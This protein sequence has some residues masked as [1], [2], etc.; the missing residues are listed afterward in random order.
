[1]ALP[2]RARRRRARRRR[3][4]DAR[5]IARFGLRCIENGHYGAFPTVG[6]GT[7][8]MGDLLEA[9]VAATDSGA[10]LVWADEKLVAGQGVE[11][12]SGLPLWAVAEGESGAVWDVHSERA[13]DAGLVC[14]PIAETVR[15][16]WAW[17]RDAE[18]L[19]DGD[20]R[21]N[22]HGTAPEKEAEVLAAWENEVKSR[23]ND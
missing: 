2:D 18:D 14:R 10:R 21:V 8:S 20:G 12:W 4:I 11:E 7:E 1:V 23:S 15:D 5:D 19:T 16:T 22:G 17:L 13:L 6:P 9:C 3:P